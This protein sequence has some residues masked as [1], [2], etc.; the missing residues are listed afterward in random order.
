[1]KL[2]SASSLTATASATLEISS[3]ELRRLMSQIEADLYHSQVYRRTLANLQTI[4]GVPAD[5][6][7]M[8]LKAVARE[9]IWLALQQFVSQYQAAGA[10]TASQTKAWQL[11]PP[12]GATSASEVPL[13][14]RQ[15]IHRAIPNPAVKST[16]YPVKPTAVKG[17]HQATTGPSQKSNQ[18][19]L[20]AP[21]VQQRSECLR[22][23][24]E[25]L[26]LARIARSLNLTQLQSQTHIP[27]H[28]IEAL[29]AGRVE[30]LPEAVYV[31]GFIRRL[32]DVLGLD[33]AALVA[34]LPAPE[35]LKSVLLP[36]AYQPEYKASRFYLTPTHLYLS[37]TA[38]VAGAVGGLA[39]ISQQSPKEVIYEPS[40]FLPSQLNASEKEGDR[41]S[42]PGLK[43][44]QNGVVAGRDLAPP[45]SL[46][47]F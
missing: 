28:H 44:S 16:D 26:R 32:G 12:C 4:Q 36:S 24:G 39:W 37:Y 31:R 17:Q 29:E 3:E 21:T 20:T 45:E 19:E 10:V 34:A 1:M 38:L 41:S 30:E 47:T 2:N 6:S 5:S 43:S 25:Q 7:Q 33:G 11:S 23:I 14:G 8:L 15:G 46:S 22:Q 40:S 18:S 9:A 42:I 27:L 35:P 13:P